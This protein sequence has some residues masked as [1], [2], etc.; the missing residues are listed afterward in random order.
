MAKLKGGGGNE[1]DFAAVK[2][3]AGTH[4]RVW[5]CKED[6]GLIKGFGFN[7]A[8]SRTGRFFAKAKD[9]VFIEEGRVE[10]VKF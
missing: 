5:A 3:E 7:L 8:T 1:W 9:V 4:L 2:W 6:F 10:K